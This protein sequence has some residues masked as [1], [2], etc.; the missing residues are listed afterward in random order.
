MSRHRRTRRPVAPGTTKTLSQERAAGGLLRA[1]AADTV[2]FHELFLRRRV[3]LSQLPL[4]AAMLFILLLVAVLDA[5]DLQDTGFQLAMVGTAVLTVVCAVVPWERLPYPSF[6][7][8]PVL[9]FVP[10]TLFR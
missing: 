8:I 2:V 5:Q 6:L 1:L 9:D 7:V 3:V 10:I 4:A